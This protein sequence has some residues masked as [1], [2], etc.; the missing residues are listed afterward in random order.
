MWDGVG[1]DYKKLLVNFPKGIISSPTPGEL[2]NFCLWFC[3]LLVI[4]SRGF[5]EA[6]GSCPGLCLGF[7]GARPSQTRSALIQ[8]WGT[9]DRFQ[10]SHRVCRWNLRPTAYGQPW[11]TEHAPLLFLSELQEGLPRGDKRTRGCFLPCYLGSRRKTIVEART[12][13]LWV[14]EGTQIHFPKLAGH[15]QREGYQLSSAIAL[16]R[17]RPSQKN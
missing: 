2:L 4:I 14:V 13:W 1:G 7:S 9:G 11:P 5:L 17:V 12:K 16:R 15:E 8:K 10:G 6:Q 3:F